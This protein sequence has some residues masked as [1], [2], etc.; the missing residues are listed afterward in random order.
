MPKD[1]DFKRLVRAR[2]ADTGERYTR[3]RAALIAQR[4]AGDQVLSDRARSLLAGVSD[5]LDGG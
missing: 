1:H 4:D 2:M 3:A 5:D